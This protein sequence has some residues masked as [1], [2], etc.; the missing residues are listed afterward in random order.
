MGYLTVN[1]CCCFDLKTGGLIIGYIELIIAIALLFIDAIDVWVKIL[2]CML[3][4]FWLYGIHWEKKDS[5]L[6]SIIAWF[7]LHI[8]F[9]ILLVTISICGLIGKEIF[10]SVESHTKVS[11]GNEFAKA[12]FDPTGGM[13]DSVSALAGGIFLVVCVIFTIIYLVVWDITRVKC[14]LYLEMTKEKKERA[15][16]IRQSVAIPEHFNSIKIESV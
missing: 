13:L 11:M 2:Y 4:G 12:S 14:S 5:L 15:A 8:L 6:P 1:G 3:V 16:A 9:T 10:H 7:I